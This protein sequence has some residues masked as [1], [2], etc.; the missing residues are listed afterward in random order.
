[1]NIIKS[2][3]L[4]YLALT[5]ANGQRSQRNQHDLKVSNIEQFHLMVAPQAS[6]EKGK[7]KLNTHVMIPSYALQFVK[8][9]GGFESS[10]EAR[11][12]L[13][14]QE[15]QQIE[16]K[17]ISQTLK[18]ADYLETV[19]KSNWYFVEH[20]FHV[21]PGKYTVVS[22][23]M[24]IDTRNRGVREKEV[25]LS[26]YK[27]DFILFPPQV[28]IHYKGSWQGVKKLMPSYQNEISFQQSF[29][30]VYVSGNVKKDIYTLKLVLKDADGVTV[31]ALDSTFANSEE[32]F[33]LQLDL[34]VKEV[35]GLRVKLFVDLEQDGLSEQQIIELKIKR[36][37]ISAHIRD[38]DEAI[39]Q[40]RYILSNDERSELSKVKKKDREQLF[41]KFWKDRD[42]APET[43]TNELMDQYYSRV[44]YANDHF[45]SFTPGWRTDMGMIYIL[46][47]PP[48]DIESIFMNSERNAH[49]NWYYYRINRSFTFYDENGFGDYR[50]TTPYIFGRTW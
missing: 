50:L 49:Q 10:F 48:D 19:G 46:F 4:F 34:P 45:T 6:S 25:D 39:D 28:M 33:T 29:V 30:P 17:S 8:E 3:F 12:S 15:G 9:D 7:I 14:D 22:E 11:I 20:D 36:P 44:R 47:G 37:G 5:V 42:P 32:Y 13:L 35:Q 40:M 31:S 26:K 23:V 41:Y 16:H 43:S 21:G 1:M 18:A 27:D 24:D 38:V 2:I